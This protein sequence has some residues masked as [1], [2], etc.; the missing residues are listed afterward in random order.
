[1]LGLILRQARLRYELDDRTLAKEQINLGEPMSMQ[2]T[3]IAARDALADVL[4][5]LGLSYRVTE[6]SK[7]FITTAA[8]LAEDTG[9]KGA[10][11]E[12]PPVKLGMSQPRKA[13]DRLLPG[14]HPRRPGAATGR[15]GPA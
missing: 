6:E 15:P 4:G 11:I 5:N 3:G 2:A 10:V 13:G 1:M 8:R 7:L 9:K 14:E 12:G